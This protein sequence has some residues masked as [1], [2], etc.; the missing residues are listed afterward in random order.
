MVYFY[1]PYVDG[2][3]GDSIIRLV[4]SPNDPA[5]ASVS[6]PVYQYHHIPYSKQRFGI[7]L[8]ELARL[9][10]LSLCARITSR[11]YNGIWCLCSP[12]LEGRVV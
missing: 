12:D 10:R 11:Q 2:L 3:F 8:D 9:P 4:L 1:C 5:S 6:V 7:L